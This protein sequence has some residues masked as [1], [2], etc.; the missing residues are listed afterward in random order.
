MGKMGNDGAP[1]MAVETSV[2]IGN[3]DF[4][5]LMTGVGADAVCGR[6]ESDKRKHM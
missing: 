4:V 5:I 6:T 1:Y 3:V 2:T